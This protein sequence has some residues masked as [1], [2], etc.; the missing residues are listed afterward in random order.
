MNRGS[1]FQLGFNP[2]THESKPCHYRKAPPNCPMTADGVQR[3]A[4][5]NKNSR[6]CRTPAV[7]EDHGNRKRVSR[8]CVWGRRGWR[9][10]CHYQNWH[11]TTLRNTAYIAATHIFVRTSPKL[12]PCMSSYA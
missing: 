7:M 9:F 6:P 1:V 3:S 11:N 8:G 5:V 4:E 2:I 10:L 12:Q